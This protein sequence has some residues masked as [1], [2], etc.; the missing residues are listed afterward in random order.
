MYINFQISYLTG[1][2][3]DITAHEKQEDGKLKELCKATGDACGGTAI[4]NE[5]FQL[6]VKIVGAPLM[7][8]LSGND[9]SA[10]LD[11]FREFETVKRTI[12][13]KKSGRVNFTVP[14]VA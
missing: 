2:T 11:L 12:K 4:D 13:P 5:F 1:G 10:Y 8:S 7:N 9:L 6:M 3:V 14:F